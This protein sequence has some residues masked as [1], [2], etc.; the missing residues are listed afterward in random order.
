MSK[1]TNKIKKSISATIK[2]TECNF[3]II[4]KP[5]FFVTTEKI[6]NVNIY[7][8]NLITK[9]ENRN[10]TSKKTH[11][12]F[13]ELRAPLFNIK[14]FLETLYEY[15]DQLTS[16]QKLEFLEI[17]TNE[18][19]RLNDLVKDILDFAEL[20]NEKNNKKNKSYI[21]NIITEILE[22]NQL[23]AKNKKLC[24]IDNIKIAENLLIK[25]CKY[26]IRIISNLLNNSIKFTY[27]RNIIFTGIKNLKFQNI[28]YNIKSSIRIYVV[29]S[30]IG[31]AKQNTKNI[32]NRF[33]RD[34]NKMNIVPGSG[35]GLNIVKDILG[36]N[37]QYLIFSTRFKKGTSTSFNLN[38]WV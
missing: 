14:S 16:N 36:K 11:E 31:I 27:P 7:I 32:F 13:H 6:K 34:N 2:T 33:Y 26:F 19:N 4:L 24:L 18:T 12:L 30:G 25:N 37:N 23:I 22:I 1:Y 38:N 28:N 15:N 17:A 35:L 21:K 8:K 5:R 3:K 9:E 10:L 29:D 20:E